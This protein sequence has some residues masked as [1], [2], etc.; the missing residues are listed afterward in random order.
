[1]GR[2]H[3]MEVDLAVDFG[4]NNHDFSREIRFAL[5]TT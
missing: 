1:M 3:C 2:K 4:P 5:K